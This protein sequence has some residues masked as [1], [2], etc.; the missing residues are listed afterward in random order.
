VRRLR[1]R[2]GIAMCPLGINEG[3]YTFI[4]IGEGQLG[5]GDGD[6]VDGV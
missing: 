4:A 6:G 1:R 5:G 3:G 2:R